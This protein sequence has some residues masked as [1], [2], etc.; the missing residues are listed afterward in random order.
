MCANVYSSIIH[1]RQQLEA[2][3]I[4]INWWIDKNFG[5]PYIGILFKNKKEWSA[6][7]CYTIDEPQNVILSERSQT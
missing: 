4:S 6:D 7:T 2:I 3:L 5:W 1:N